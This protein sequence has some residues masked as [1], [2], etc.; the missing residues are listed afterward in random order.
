MRWVILRCSVLGQR[1]RWSMVDLIIM[2]THCI[3][4]TISMMTVWSLR[5]SFVVVTVVIWLNFI[6]TAIGL[7]VNRGGPWIFAFRFRMAA[8]LIGIVSDVASVVSRGGR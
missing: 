3:W 6:P 4:L 7:I 8:A 1:P 2:M 5:L